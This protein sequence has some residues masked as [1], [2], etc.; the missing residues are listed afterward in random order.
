MRTFKAGDLVLNKLTGCVH[1][2]ITDDTF[3][4]I[5]S[6][7]QEDEKDFTKKHYDTK[8]YTSKYKVE[9]ADTDTWKLLVNLGDG[10]AA[11]LGYKNAKYGVR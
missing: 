4:H 6:G 2:L 5:V 7:G 8:P 3:I 1:L 10:V 9:K 11:Y